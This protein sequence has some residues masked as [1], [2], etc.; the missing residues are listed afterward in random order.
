MKSS[1][2]LR[3][4]NARKQ[5][6]RSVQGEEAIEDGASIADAARANGLTLTETP[7]I[8]G[9]GADRADAAFASPQR[10]HPR[11]KRVRADERR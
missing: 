6:S 4:R 5:C 9:A 10:R 1:P 3:S 2:G 7:L 11:S 8:T